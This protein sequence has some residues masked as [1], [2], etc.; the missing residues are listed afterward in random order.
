MLKALQKFDSQ[1]LQYMTRNQK[2][3]TWF[4]GNLKM[5]AVGC[6]FFFSENTARETSEVPQQGQRAISNCPGD[7]W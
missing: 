7:M 5:K 2:N 4:Q 6:L 3:K 1:S